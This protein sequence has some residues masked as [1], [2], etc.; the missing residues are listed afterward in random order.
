[1]APRHPAWFSPL[2]EQLGA[3]LAGIKRGPTSSSTTPKGT[4]MSDPIELTES[5]EANALLRRQMAAYQNTIVGHITDSLLESSS[6]DTVRWATGLATALDGAGLN[7]D[8]ALGEHLA[9]QGLDY[10]HLT[11]PT[12]VNRSA[13]TWTALSRAEWDLTKTWVDCDG[14]AWRWSGDELN[15]HALMKADGHPDAMLDG[16]SIFNGPLAVQGGA[17]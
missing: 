4:L 5:R 3:A 7:I 14:T 16:L 6:A 13:A 1:M 9:N 8:T 15:G 10:N 12:G 11:T 17:K 2:T